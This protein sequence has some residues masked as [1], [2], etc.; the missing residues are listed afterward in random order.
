MGFGRAHLRGLAS[1]RAGALF[2]E[3]LYTLIIVESG[4]YTV[5]NSQGVR[6]SAWQVNGLDA[7]FHLCFQSEVR[8]ASSTDPELSF[9]QR[10]GYVASH[11]I[12]S[13][14]GRS[15]GA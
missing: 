12:S 13:M 7:V 15:L 3:T 4:R 11:V 8:V 5:P 14:Q 6:G 2:A 9:A 10:L 1:E